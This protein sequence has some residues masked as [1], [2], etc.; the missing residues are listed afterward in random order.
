MLGST[1]PVAALTTILSS[2]SSTRQMLHGGMSWSPGGRIT[3][4]RWTFGDGQS[5]TTVDTNIRLV[6]EHNY[7]PG[8]YTVCLMITD[9][10]GRTATNCSLVQPGLLTLR[11]VQ[12]K[13]SREWKVCKRVQPLNVDFYVLNAFAPVSGALVKVSVPGWQ[14]LSY[15]DAYGKASFQID[16]TRFTITCSKRFTTGGVHVEAS[17][18]RFQPTSQTLWMQ[19]CDAIFQAVLKSK[20]YKDSWIDRLAGYYALK[21]SSNRVYLILKNHQ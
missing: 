16:P 21:S 2:N 10:I 9:D 20:E 4:Y 1:Q 12:E 19:D 15:T 6:T 8:V 3:Q 14:D 13:G 5:E 18:V 7:S 17:K 11:H